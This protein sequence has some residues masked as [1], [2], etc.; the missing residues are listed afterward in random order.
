[1]FH[2]IYF[3]DCVSKVLIKLM[4]KTKTSRVWV[5]CDLIFHTTLWNLVRGGN[6]EKGWA[7]IWKWQRSWPNKHLEQTASTL[8]TELRSTTTA[9]GV[10]RGVGNE[11][12]HFPASL[13][14]AFSPESF[15]GTFPFYVPCLCF[16][17]LCLFPVCGWEEL[18]LY[19]KFS[20]F[21]NPG[22]W[23]TFLNASSFSLLHC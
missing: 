1:M 19:I 5:G 14:E 9:G 16:V 6:R 10:G 7:V 13:R 18:F 15:W 12:S 8:S 22:G 20:Q 17:I 11:H 2:I 4:L 23:H 21:S 3:C